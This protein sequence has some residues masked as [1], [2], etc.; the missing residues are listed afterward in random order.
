MG[1]VA[2]LPGV[3]FDFDP[4]NLKDKE[5]ESLGTLLEL[6][7]DGKPRYTIKVLASSLEVS[8]SHITELK[9]LSS[10]KTKFTIEKYSCRHSA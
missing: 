6:Y 7:A 9:K 5:T 3:Q 1:A 2:V 8:R 4:L 10:V